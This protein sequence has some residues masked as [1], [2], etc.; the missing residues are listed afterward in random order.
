MLVDSAEKAGIGIGRHF[1]AEHPKA[2]G[3]RAQIEAEVEVTVNLT[4]GGDELVA[5]SFLFR[6]VAVRN[7]SH[8]FEHLQVVVEIK[9]AFVKLFPFE[10]VIRIGLAQFFKHVAILCLALRVGV[11][12]FGKRLFEL[13]LAVEYAVHRDTPVHANTVLVS[14]RE[15]LVFAVVFE[16]QRRVGVHFGLPHG[17]A[18]AACLDKLVVHGIHARFYA[19]AREVS[20]SRAGEAECHGKVSRLVTVE[21]D[22]GHARRLVGHVILAVR[23]GHV[24]LA[25]IDTEYAEVA[26]LA[27]PHPVVGVA[28][29]LAQRRRRCEHEAHVGVNAVHGYVEFVRAVVRHQLCP[30]CGILCRHFLNEHCL[31]RVEQLVAAVAPYLMLRAVCA[32]FGYNGQHAVGYTLLAQR[33]ADEQARH[34]PFLLRR[35]GVKAVL[36][37]VVLRG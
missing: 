33:E 10:C 27:R 7:C 17:K 12:P 31:H 3:K 22:G 23:R 19:V 32:L 2:G 11:Y 8:K 25:G 37:V 14:V 34:V 26:R 9:Y 28:A 5:H 1:V 24:V 15:S 4:H 20:V 13:A 36:Y 30:E 16:A 21:R 35:C 29:E 6:I 18:Q